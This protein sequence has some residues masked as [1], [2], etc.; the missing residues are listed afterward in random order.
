MDTATILLIITTITS[1]L[2]ATFSFLQHAKSI[3]FASCCFTAQV[4][5]QDTVPTPVASST[6]T[7]K[8]VPPKTS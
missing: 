2:S 8:L 7:T 1:S 6:E 5:E 3:K 4:D